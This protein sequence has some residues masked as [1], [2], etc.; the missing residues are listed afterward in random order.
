MSQALTGTRQYDAFG[1]LAS[2][3]GTWQGPFGYA[4]GFG[5]QEDATGLRL[6]GHRLYDASTG[7]FLTR[8]PIQDGRNWYV[9]CENDPIIFEDSPGLQRGPTFRSPMVPSVR[10]MPPYSYPRRPTPSLRTP[11]I[12]PS[13]MAP[14]LHQPPPGVPPIT[15]GYPTNTGGGTYWNLP[16]GSQ[17]RFM[18]GNPNA[19]YVEQRRPYVVWIGADGHYRDISGNRVPR[20]SGPA[21]ID[22]LSF[23]ISNPLPK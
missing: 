22:A 11:W 8:D 1:N 3:T 17:I 18:P 19:P 20:R 2:T 13:I 15:I 21:H 6:L 9:Y 5:Y 23:Y 4:G 14:G 7:R 12:R 16:G 10:R